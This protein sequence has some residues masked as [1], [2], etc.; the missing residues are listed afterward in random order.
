MTSQGK[1]GAAPP[2]A[3]GSPGITPGQSFPFFNRDLLRV[4]DPSKLKRALDMLRAERFQLFAEVRQGRVVGVVRSQ[5]TSK[6]VYACR[7]AEDGS[8]ACCTQ[9]LR[10]CVVSRDS[11]CKHLLVLV[12]GLVNAGQF[13]PEAAIEW[14]ERSRGQEGRP[15]K[16][17]TTAIFLRYKGAEAGT[18]DW[19]PTETIPEDFYAM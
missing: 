7:L 13:A 6:R 18:V 12:L 1:A 15:D 17:E 2:A 10:T 5:S 14:L 16:E 19:R 11:P 8:Y 4:T 3:G 9:N